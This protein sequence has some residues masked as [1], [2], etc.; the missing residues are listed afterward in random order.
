MT[1]LNQLSAIDAAH[2][3][4]TTSDKY[5]FVSSR[6]IIDNLQT[7]GFSPRKIEIQRA[8][9]I[10]RQGFQ[11]HIV[12]LRHNELMPVVGSEFPE[13]IL[14][15][16]HDGSSSVKMMLGVFRLV[17]SN[18][19][20]SGSVQDEIRYVHRKANVELINDG[21]MRLVNSAGRLTDA[22]NR[23]KSRELTLVERNEFIRQAAKLRYDEPEENQLLSLN[24]LR[25]YED[26][27]DNLWLTF[28]RVQENLTQGKR[29]SG[30]RRITSPSADVAINRGLWNLAE[31]ILN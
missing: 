28:N 27:G 21:A 18:G 25:R 17:C 8:N 7:L 13:I 10:E 22:I 24:S 23:M 20:V 30:I 1:T 6:A 19:M 3:A 2:A 26:R 9:K 29:Y 5:G 14:M 15:N 16:S 4:S 31:S 12:R 11:R